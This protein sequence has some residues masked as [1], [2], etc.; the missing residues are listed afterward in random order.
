MKKIY[1]FIVVALCCVNIAKAA[2]PIDKI[3]GIVYLTNI[4]Y[5][6]GII[7]FVDEF[8]QINYTYDRHYNV[9]GYEKG[10]KTAIYAANGGYAYGFYEENGGHGRPSNFAHAETS[11]THYQSAGG[12]VQINVTPIIEAARQLEISEIHFVICGRFLDA[13]G[14]WEVF[15]GDIAGQYLNNYVD[16]KIQS[17]FCEFGNDSYPVEEEDTQLTVKFRVA[18]YS[19]ISYVIQRNSEERKDDWFTI[20]TGTLSTPEVKAG[21]SHDAVLPLSAELSKNFDLRFV[22]TVTKT[23]ETDT[24]YTSVGCKYKYTSP[25]GIS[26]YLYP[27][28]KRYINIPPDCRA[29]N[30]VC[31]KPVKVEKNAS[32]E[33]FVITMPAADLL[34]EE[35]TPTYTVKFLDADYTLLDKQEVECGADA[36][37]PA[38]PSYGGYTFIGWSKDLTNVHSNMS[39]MAKYDIGN[40]YMLNTFITDHKNEVFPFEGFAN[41]ETR[42]MVGDKMT[43]TAD[44]F[45]TSNA[46]LYYETAQWLVADSA[47]NWQPNGGIKVADYTTPNQGQWYNQ[48]ISICYDV[49][50]SYIH[51]FEYKV[52][53]RFYLLIAGVKVY[54]EPYE[55]DVYY[56]LTINSNTGDAV[57]AEN[58]AGDYIQDLTAVLPARYNDTVH[59]YSING[60]EGACLT[61]ARQDQP[62]RD[63]FSGEDE[64]GDAYF[65]CPGEKETINVSSVQYIVTF[66]VPGQPNI[67]YGNGVISKQTVA[68]GQAA[69]VPADPE[70]AGYIFKGWRSDDPSSYPDDAYLSIPPTADRDFPVNFTAEMEEL[71]DVPQY[72]VKFFDKDSVNQ[73]GTDQLVNEGEN[74]VPPTAPEVSGYHF[75]G[76]NKPYA[77]I[78]A[79]T[80][81]VALYGEDG[82][83][84][85]VT[86]KNWDNSLL[87]TE[88]V[89]D[90]EAAQGV[91]ATREGYT[92]TGW[93]EDISHV[94]S[95]M[96]VTAQF[97]KAVYLIT[98]TM[99]G[100][101]IFSEEVEHG[102]MPT[103]HTAIEAQGKPSTEQYTYTF[104]H[105]NPAIVAATADATYEAIF[106][107]ALRKYNVRF[108]NWNHTLL[109]E[110]QVAY[111]QAATAP[112]N[113]TREGY[114]F[115]GWD[116]DFSDV[117]AEL[118]VT[119][120]FEKGNGEQ[121]IED[122]I[123]PADRAAKVLIDG[124]L[125][126]VMPDGR[127]LNALGQSVR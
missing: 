98:Y 35:I 14:D 85:T 24:A 16:A 65:I 53:V 86:Y 41:S 25:S 58:N 90:G 91:V 36:V 57:F 114:A 39:V 22:G 37:A 55:I 101:T 31:S 96:T 74:A 70:E 75:V 4:Q 115:K 77:T 93:S 88:Q 26:E 50:T 33:T 7:S 124:A 1:L 42:A 119:A 122:I 21:G 60:A 104:D 84:W 59:V 38:D 43:F 81:I 120:V 63:L 29:F 66:T 17:L 19:A 121:G 113:P 54:S 47:F 87:G 103:A 80:E 116:R 68:C 106:T 23:N 95:D 117:R 2:D 107:Q 118:T 111:G 27:G 72:T 67:G 92:F 83:T 28:T 73:I 49:N 97:K 64:N 100:E 102:E 51:A 10:E 52:G 94:T 79:N 3:P 69:E 34:I 126:I 18:G 99:D 105:W 44:I 78:T 5:Q 127:I 109:K 45:A 89:N 40:E 13:S 82:I 110:Q 6:N 76:W 12:P 15:E 32:G 11:I 30:Y 61:F 48:E 20:Q 123:A 125:Y 108:Q 62:T 9:Y 71:P 8:R 46:T 112:A 56:P